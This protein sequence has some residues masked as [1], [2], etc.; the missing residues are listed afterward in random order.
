MKTNTFISLIITFAFFIFACIFYFTVD[1]NYSQST[2]LIKANSYFSEGNFFQSARYYKKLISMGAEDDQIYK[3]TATSLINIGDYDKAIYYLNKISQTTDKSE[4]YYDLAYSYYTKSQISNS[5][6][7]LQNAVSYLEQAISI[8]PKNEMAYRLIGD[9]CENNFSFSR[10]RTWYQKAI[11]EKISDGSEFYNLIAYTYFKE[12]DFDKA[13][14]TY[15]QAI[16]INDKNVSAY[17]SLGTI[18][19]Q[20]FEFDKAEDI[21]KKSLKI[22]SDTV[23][24]YFN[25]GFIYYTKQDYQQALAYYNKA[26][27]IDKNDGFVNYYIAKIYNDTGDKENAI[28]FLKISAYSGNEDAIKELEKIKKGL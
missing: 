27:A 6:D 21:Y 14:Q 19:I 20:Q 22:Y 12:N 23:T 28:K 3:K 18:Y 16:K 25:L 2:V 8:N 1:K 26:L 13:I 15:Q 11:D 24:P 7:E 10:A 17:Y 4:I 9:I 5:K